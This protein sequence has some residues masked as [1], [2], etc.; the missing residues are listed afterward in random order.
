MWQKAQS[1]PSQGVIDQPHH[2]GRPAM[3]WR[4]YQNHFVYVSIEGGAQGIQ[5]PKAVQRGNLVAWL[6]CMTDRPDKWA[7][8]A[9]SSAT[10][11]TY[12]SYKCHGATLGK[13]CK[14]SEV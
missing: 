3:C 9:E 14:E 8:R 10:A 5:C 13:K 1:Q 6:S 2:L 4:I 11:P 12:S 7:P